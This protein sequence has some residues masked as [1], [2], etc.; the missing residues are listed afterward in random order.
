MEMR[1]KLLAAQILFLVIM[2]AGCKDN[3][4]TT[5]N[6]EI[7]GIVTST[8]PDGSVI[9]VPQLKIY[10][11][12]KNV[13]PDTIDIK[14]NKKLFIDSTFTDAGGNYK[15][16]N[17]KE[18]KYGIAPYTGS[19][20]IIVYKDQ[21]SP[22]P[23]NIV[24]D[25]KQQSYKINFSVVYPGEDYPGDLIPFDL[26]VKFKNLNWGQYTMYI[27][28]YEYYCLIPGFMGNYRMEMGEKFIFNQGFNFKMSY[29]W[30][31]LFYTMSNKFR[32]T[33]QRLGEDTY[34]FD[35]DL[36]LSA[37]P[38]SVTFEYDYQAKTFTRIE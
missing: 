34:S 31:M 2:F 13:K 12:D 18:G 35:Y 22:D 20:D 36:T 24:I 33:F 28:R 11:L 29:G 16:H 9:K 15:F 7:T 17:L 10:L 37:C 32:F 27:Y 23:I 26:N 14:N 21:S 30:T 4:V 38:A 5:V 3:P 8:S 6:G 19:S 1:S 25:S